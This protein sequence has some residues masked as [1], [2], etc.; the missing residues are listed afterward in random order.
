MGGVARAPV[1]LTI[2]GVYRHVEKPNHCFCLL[3]LGD[4]YCGLAAQTVVDLQRFAPGREVFVYTDRP[5]FFRAYPNCRITK[6]ANTGLKRPYNDKRF[7]VQ[8][9]LQEYQTAICIDADTRFDR[10]IPMDLEFGPGIEA[11]HMEPVLIHKPEGQNPRLRKLFARLAGR[12]GIDER[13]VVWIQESLFS[14]TRDD[15]GRVDEF[16]RLWGIL[17]VE[18]QLAGL[19][20]DGHPIGFAAESLDWKIGKGSA[21]TLLEEAHSHSFHHAKSLDFIPLARANKVRKLTNPRWLW[22]YANRGLRSAWFFGRKLRNSG[23]SVDTGAVKPRTPD[24]TDVSRA[25]KQLAAG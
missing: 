3:A 8:R 9:G 13:D 24:S 20:V 7:P 18:F 14:V 25:E 6:H 15:T 11:A 16:F 22:R 17:A 1:S 23:W 2:T 10:P 21:I 19:H 4:Y 5:A 12:M